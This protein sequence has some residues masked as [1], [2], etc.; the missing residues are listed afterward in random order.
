MNRKLI[1]AG[2]ALFLVGAAAIGAATLT[3][4]T[5]SGDQPDNQ[6]VEVGL[7]YS[8]T[9]TTVTANLTSGGTVVESATDSDSSGGTGTAVLDLTG[10][11]VADYSL[12]VTATDESNVSV[13]EIRMNT[14][15]DRG[16]LTANET[17]TVDVGYDATQVTNST[18]EYLDQN[19]NVI[20][21][22]NLSFDPIDYQDGS[23]VLTAEW[24]PSQDYNYTDVRVTTTPAYGYESMFTVNLGGIVGGGGS[25]GLFGASSEQV[26]GFALLLGGLLVLS[27]R[28][29][30]E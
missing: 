5:I 23:G 21:T 3:N 18:V 14:T 11:Q 30:F 22:T 19:G 13:S 7:D 8:G 2:L 17:Y 16:N 20:N 6:Q 29:V 1:L 15:Q 28:E 10:L 25:G 24:T 4:G 27:S 26:L 12:N 9:G